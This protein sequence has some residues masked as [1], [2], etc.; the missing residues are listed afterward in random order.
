[1]SVSLH[2]ESDRTREELD[3]ALD[4]KA[5][6]IT[7][8]EQMV[9]GAGVARLFQRHLRTRDQTHGHKYPEGGRRSHFWRAAAQSVTFES[10]PDG[11][12]VSV[13]HQG[14]R[15]R[16]EG[17]PDGIRPVNAKA[18]AIPANGAAYGRIPSEFNDLRIVV[19]KNI[20]RAALV[21]KAK[22]DG[23]HDT[24]MFWLVRKTKPIQADHTVL[25]TEQEILSEAI[26]RL[27]AM[28][29][30]KESQNVE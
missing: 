18:L 14:V 1:M 9:M 3:R 16:Y 20:N 24:V 30:R 23:A 10:D 26:K 2:I 27:K 5:G 19:F 6:P 11:L 21:Q 7:P 8:E 17:D 22:K 4:D 12:T 13:T 29:E 15:L 28:R 25:P